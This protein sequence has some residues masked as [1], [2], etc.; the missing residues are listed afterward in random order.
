MSQSNLPECFELLGNQHAVGYAH[1]GLTSNCYQVWCYLPSIG[2][3]Y[4]ADDVDT[5]AAFKHPTQAG[6][7]VKKIRD[8]WKAGNIKSM[9]DVLKV[10]GT[11][12]DCIQKD[13]LP[14]GIRQ[15][16]RGKIDDA[17]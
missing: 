1:D 5:V 6:Q 9:D 17:Q 8:E 13:E 16:I 10:L 4:K 14:L 11:D 15:K 2:D 12:G 3:D 7:S